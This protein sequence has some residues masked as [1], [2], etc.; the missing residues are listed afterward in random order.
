M[1]HWSTHPAILVFLGGG[2]GSLLRYGAGRLLAQTVWESQ[3]PLAILLVNALASGLLGVVMGWSLGRSGAGPDSV[4]LLIGVG[5]CGGLSTFSSFS[6]D[7]VVLLQNGRVVAALLN[8]GLNLLL[9]LSA[10]A[11]GLIVVRTIF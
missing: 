10:T 5:V 9:C 4:R 11:L 6:H 3:F 8:I 7:T 2:L 1:P